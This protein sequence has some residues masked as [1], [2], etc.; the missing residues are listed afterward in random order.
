MNR[1]QRA[2]LANPNL[3]FGASTFLGIPVG[4]NQMLLKFADRE[5]QEPYEQKILFF[6]PDGT[7]VPTNFMG[8]PYLMLVVLPSNIA[9][10]EI[11][12]GTFSSCPMLETVV[13]LEDLAV[14]EEEMFPACPRLKFSRL[15]A[16]TIGGAAFGEN[17]A[18][19]RVELPNVIEIGSQAFAACINA[20]IVL[21]D[22]VESVG[23]NAFNE[24]DNLIYHGSLEDAPWGAKKWNGVPQE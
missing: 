18:L 20:T 23:E 16:T 14:I 19:K 13:G 10:M 2:A 15:N 5:E 7:Q 21:N 8:N 6:C 4:T 11:N 1:N 22:D 12:P 3:E 24:I 9:G 17:I